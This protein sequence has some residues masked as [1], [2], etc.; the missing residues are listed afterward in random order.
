[1]RT[2]KHPK[3]SALNKRKQELKDLFEYFSRVELGQP[4]ERSR[5]CGTTRTYVNST[6]GNSSIT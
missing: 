1:M 5:R 6:T 4:R 2:L 3:E